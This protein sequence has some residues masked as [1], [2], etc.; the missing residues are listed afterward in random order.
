MKKYILTQELLQSIANVLQDRPYKEV[1][2][3]M[4]QLRALKPEPE[5]E[6]K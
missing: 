1:F 6:S 2:L 3:V 4:D 5:D